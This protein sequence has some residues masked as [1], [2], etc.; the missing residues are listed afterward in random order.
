M[1]VREGVSTEVYRIV[2]DEVVTF[3]RVLPEQGQGFASEALAHQL[4]RARGMRVPEVLYVEH[5]NPALERAVM[6][7]SAISGGPIGHNADPAAL[8]DGL[9]D[10]GREMAL[11]GKVPVDGWGWIARE[12]PSYTQLAAS[13]ATWASWLDAEFAAPIDALAASTALLPS[14]SQ[15]LQARF[16]AQQRSPPDTAPV[17]A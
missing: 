8:A 1:R 15:R 17:L 5:R 16:V 10:A 2:A 3:G 4:L 11:L 6:I 9:A 14:Q 12:A 7:T 13:H